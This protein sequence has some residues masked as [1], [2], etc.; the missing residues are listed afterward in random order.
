MKPNEINEDSILVF[1]YFTASGN[2]SPNIISEAEALILALIE[3][4]KDFNIFVLVHKSYK[5]LIKDYKNVK[6]IFITENLENW[7]NNNAHFFKRAMFIAAEDN[8]N[9]YNLSKIL[10][11]NNVK[12][13]NSSSVACFSTSNK[14]KTYNLLNNLISQ[15]KTI[16]IDSKD[17]LIKF[18]NKSTK[19]IVKPINGVDCENVKIIN[20]LEDIHNLELNSEMIAQEFIEGIDVSVS[21][22]SDDKRVVPISLN[23]QFISPEKEEYLGACLPYN[24]E[25]KNEVFK[26]AKIVTESIEGI[27]GFV[28]VDLILTKNKIY[29]LEINSRFTTP[30]VGLQKIANFNIGKSII[31]LLDNKINLDDFENMIS[32]SGSVLFKKEKNHLNIEV[33]K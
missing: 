33:L 31:Y 14:L 4:L 28:G 25:N 11:D 19:I 30:Y 10:E 32:F 29:F 12:I 16:K 27:K 2:R 20:S 1:E 23:K 26:I 21:L 17:S 5:Y 22:I 8:M 15:P 18:F 6:P 9:L 3:D 24:H 7:L 13:Y